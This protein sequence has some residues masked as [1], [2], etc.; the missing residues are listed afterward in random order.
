MATH[1]SVL[2]WSIPGT[3]EP[4][5]LPSMGSHRVGHDWSD[6][7]AA[8]VNQPWVYMCSPS[9]TPL[10]VPPHPILQGHPST[11]ALNALPH[12]SNLDWWSISHMVI[13]MFQCHSLKSSHLHLLPQSP[14]V[15]SLY[16]CLF[17][18]ITYRVII[19]IFLYSR[20]M[21]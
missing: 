6:L 15:C 1:S 4:D 7:A 20:Y 2:A 8:D 17:C 13:Y 11:L 12:A 5:G 16:L 3:G 14:N 10:H 18:F 9:W 19:T 21:H